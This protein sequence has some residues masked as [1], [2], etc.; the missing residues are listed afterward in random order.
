M[1]FIAREIRD[2]VAQLRAA[3]AVQSIFGASGHHFEF[4]APIEMNTLR[5]WER[6]HG[7]ELPEE[8]RDYLLALGNG[9]AGPFF[10][11][12]PLGMWEGH[13]IVSMDDA[14]GD[15]RAPFPHREAWNLPAARFEPP[16]FEDDDAENAWNAQLD[17]DY[18]DRSLVNGA[19]WIADHGCALRTLLVVT[20]RER[21]NVWA[22]LRAENAGLTPHVDRDGRHLTFGDWYMAWLEQRLAQAATCLS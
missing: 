9:G 7:V 21:G 2:Q 22:D 5:A 20:G 18:D 17:A 3:G 19:I 11:I 6:A 16:D 14:L 13:E 4:N 15:L 12:H 10:G 1:A 8:Y